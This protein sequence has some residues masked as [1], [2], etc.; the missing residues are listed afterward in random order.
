MEECFRKRFQRLQDLL[1]SYQD[2]VSGLSSE[3]LNQPPPVGGWSI[4]QVIHHI[5][6]AEAGI[7]KYIQNKL[8]NPGESKKAGIRSAYRAALLK[9]ALRSKRKFRAPKVLTEPTGPYEV[10]DLF[11]QWNK[12]RKNLEILFDSIQGEHKNRQLFKH[13][14]VG[15]INLKQTLGFMGDHMERHLEQIRHIRSTI[16]I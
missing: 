13:P 14:V 3:Q 1:Q 9:Y 5:S 6:G 4:N 7:I 15:K 8:I 16:S 11:A 10:A 12:T 2:E